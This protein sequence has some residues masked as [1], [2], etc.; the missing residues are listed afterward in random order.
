MNLK[1]DADASV[2]FVS[3]VKYIISLKDSEGSLLVSPNASAVY[4]V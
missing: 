2:A 4:V 3:G 1:I